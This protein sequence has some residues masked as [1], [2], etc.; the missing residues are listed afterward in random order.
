MLIFIDKN[1]RLK[2][3]LFFKTN[4][5]LN[6]LLT[7]NGVNRSMITIYI[8][9]FFQEPYELAKLFALRV[10]QHKPVG[11]GNARISQHY[12][13]SLN[14][15]FNHYSTSE[16]AIIFEEDLITSP[17]VFMYFSQTK[18]LL[19][20]DPSLYCISAFNDN[21]YIHSSSDERLCYRVE[22]MPGEL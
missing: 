2:K 1:F 11:E 6:S 9:G 8:D 19:V 15:L 22:G 13:F 7:A 10:V 17:D 14:E 5:M 20:E 4:S 16:F 3:Y 12:Y 18:N 21:S